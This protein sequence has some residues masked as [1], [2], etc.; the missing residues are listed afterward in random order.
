MVGGSA[1][2]IIMGGVHDVRV[3]ERGTKR[4]STA[5]KPSE[6]FAGWGD[7]WPN[8]VLSG[9]IGG[10]ALFKHELC[11]NRDNLSNLRV[12][13]KHGPT[14]NKAGSRR[15]GG[16]AMQHNMTRVK[17][18]LALTQTTLTTKGPGVEIPFRFL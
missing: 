9:S 3:G 10:C 16:A 4:A 12:A 14:N 7:V 8:G 15:Q 11:C 2:W 17:T 18:R 13:N 6:R 1:N 5:I